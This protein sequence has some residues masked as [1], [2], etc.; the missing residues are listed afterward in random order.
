MGG[1][2]IL[3]PSGD[4]RNKERRRPEFQTHKP[5]R[6]E[7]MGTDQYGPWRTSSLFFL[8]APEWKKNPHLIRADICHT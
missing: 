7:R 8:S 3:W 6:Q 5:Q 4:S 1:Q 2:N